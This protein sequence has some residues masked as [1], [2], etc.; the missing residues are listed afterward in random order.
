[1]NLAFSRFRCSWLS[2]AGL[3]FSGMSFGWEFYCSSTCTSSDG[4]SNWRMK[5]RG[6]KITT[7]YGSKSVQIVQGIIRTNVC[8]WGSVQSNESTVVLFLNAYYP[9]CYSV[10]LGP[11]FRSILC[12]SYCSSQMRY[13]LPLIHVVIS[14]V[15]MC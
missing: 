8:S 4:F 12:Y 5:S 11:Y 1:M 9:S 3:Q 13:S 14:L 6:S 15:I 2:C 10:S 7:L